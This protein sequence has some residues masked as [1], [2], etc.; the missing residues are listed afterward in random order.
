MAA[1]DLL[2][3]GRGPS[4]LATA[5]AAQRRGSGR[6]LDCAVIERG[7]LPAPDRSFRAYRR[8]GNIFTGNGRFDGEGIVAML[9]DRLRTA[10]A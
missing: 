5:I 3:V 9:G 2:I 7:V 6:G 1:R 8:T 10:S 4:G